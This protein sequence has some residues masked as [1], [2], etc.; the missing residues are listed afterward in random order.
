MNEL[1][2]DRISASKNLIDMRDTLIAI[3]REIE[4]TDLQLEDEVNLTDLP[5]FGGP[6][7]WDIEGAWSWD[8]DYILCGDGLEYWA[9]KPRINYIEAE[10][11]AAIWAADER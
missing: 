11:E 6:G 5:T 7:P 10:A 9:I 3:A 4:D 1:A 2:K 8:A